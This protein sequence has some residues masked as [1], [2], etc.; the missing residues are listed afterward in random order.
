MRPRRQ[1]LVR[2]TAPAAPTSAP[3][4]ADVTDPF[5]RATGLADGEPT[6]MPAADPAGAAPGDAPAS[7]PFADEPGEAPMAEEAPAEADPF[8]AGDSK[9][10]PMEDDPF[11][12]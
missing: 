9:D 4:G 5:A 7:D 3:S 6:E 11:G 2:Q 10:A 12:S 1:T 8:G